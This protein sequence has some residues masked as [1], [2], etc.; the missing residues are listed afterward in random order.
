MSLIIA[1]KRLQVTKGYKKS[2]A[3]ITGNQSLKSIVTCN[4]IF[5][6]I[7]YL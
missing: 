7:K 1:K 2:Y 4:L 3:K 5:L 6:Y